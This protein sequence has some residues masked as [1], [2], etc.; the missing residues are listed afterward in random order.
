MAIEADGTTVHYTTAAE[1]ILAEKKLDKGYHFAPGITIM[2]PSKARA[3]HIATLVDEIGDQSD[4]D[5]IKLI[6]QAILGE[7]YGPVMDYLDDFPIEG[8]PDLLADLLEGL[9]GLVPKQRDMEAFMNRTERRMA[10]RRPDL[11]ASVSNK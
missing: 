1:R 10:E 4:E 11:Y 6:F 3:E 5:D 2:A 8:Y 7:Q 9:L